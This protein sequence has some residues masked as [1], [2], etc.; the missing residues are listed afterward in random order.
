MRGHR[1]AK[2]GVRWE[3]M[4]L[5]TP[6]CAINVIPGYVPIVRSQAL[7][8]TLF[9]VTLLLLEELRRRRKI[10]GA[11]CG[12]LHGVIDQRA[13]LITRCLT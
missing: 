8:Y 4:L 10:A 9:A 3:V 2:R 13:G 11:P 7:T 12:C 6:L 5:L 1:S